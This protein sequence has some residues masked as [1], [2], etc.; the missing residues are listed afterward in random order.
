MRYI[1][2]SST[3]FA[4]F[5]V[6]LVS[7]SLFMVPYEVREQVGV[8]RSKTWADDTFVLMP[9]ENRTY[10]LDSVL[11]NVSII[12]V[13]MESSD[14]IVLRIISDNTGKL[15]YERQA[16]GIRSSYWTP[17]TEAYEIWRFVFH[18][19]SSMSVNVTAK[20][21]EFYFKITEYQDVTYY[22][23]LLDPIYGYSGIIALIVA[24]GLNV[25]QV[26]RQPKK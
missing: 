15:W 14:F 23:S 1:I 11:E 17:P 26:S 9:L 10:S 25:I 18:N 3:I 19:P 2:I 7:G 13:D 6:I 8:D 20:V 21:R 12:Q 22:R 24:I 5:G 16:R 4:V